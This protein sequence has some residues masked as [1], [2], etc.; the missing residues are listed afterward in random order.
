MLFLGEQED[1]QSL[2]RS[3]ESDEELEEEFFTDLQ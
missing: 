3:C 2:Y 1:L